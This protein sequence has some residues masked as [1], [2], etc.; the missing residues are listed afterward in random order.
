MFKNIIEQNASLQLKEDILSWRLAPSMLFFGPADSGKGSTALECA[1]ILSCEDSMSWQC[2]CSACQQHRYLQH[3]DLLILGQR[4]FAAEI[5]AC[6][7]VF[8]RNPSSQSAK[9]LF[10]RSI[11]KLQ[12]RFSPVLMEKDTKLGSLSSVLQPLEENLSELWADNTGSNQTA[13]EKLCNLLVKDALSLADAVTQNI[14]IDH[15]RRAAY[16]CRLAPNG[17]HKT[18]IIE[19]AQNMR[20]DARNSLL[21]LLEE[22]PAAVSIIL[23]TPRREAIIPTILSRL[24]PY[25]FLRRS[26]EGEKEVLR[27]VFQDSFGEKSAE[28]SPLVSAYLE[29]FLPRNTGTMYPLA[30]FFLASLARIAFFSLKKKGCDV[31]WLISAL[32]ERYAPIAENAGFAR[33]V[34]SADIVKTVLEKSGNFED[35][36]F[37]GFLRLL[38][39]LISDVTRN[40][41]EPH[42]IIC[43]DDFKKHL[44]DAE[45]AASV[46]NQNKSLV[47]E[48]LVFKLKKSMT[49]AVYA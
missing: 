27:R 3:S 33:C 48:A 21:K 12:L 37:T 8:L 41:N 40:A 20:D 22:P 9:L 7:N 49:R 38:L 35:G 23:T 13:L 39:D 29:S 43:S 14:P 36:Y 28:G 26:A 2:T 5:T 32:G 6:N 19:N 10:T 4:S 17:K 18:L 16:W 25:R 42:F 47:L 24:R 45:T 44:A 15:I 34:K 46:L 30:A 1:R 31:P 11:R